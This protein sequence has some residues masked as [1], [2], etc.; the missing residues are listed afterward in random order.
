MI[1]MNNVMH[2]M[3][4]SYSAIKT[5]TTCPLKYQYQYIEKRSAE[6]GEAAVFGSLIH[7]ALHHYHNTVPIPSSEE[8]IHF[9]SKNWKSTIYDD[10]KVEQE[11]FREG[12]RVLREYCSVINPKDHHIIALEKPFQVVISDTDTS[13]S[14]GDEQIVL[15]GIIDRIEKLPDGRFEIIDYKTGRTLPSQENVDN[16]LQLSVYWMAVREQWPNRDI[17]GTVVSLYFVK[18]QEKIQS[19][20]TS[21][22]IEETK[23]SIRDIV[24]SIQQSKFSPTPSA[25]CDYCEYRKE[26]PMMKHK[27]RH[28]RKAQSEESASVLVKEYIQLKD[29]EKK[30]KKRLKELSAEL[31]HFCREHDLGRLF[32]PENDFSI[33]LSERVTYQYDE[34]QLQDIL[35]SIGRWDEV[36]KIDL[37]MLKRILPELPKD[38]QESIAALQSVKKKSESLSIK[39]K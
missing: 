12:V 11:R 25:L 31:L 32:G 24:S 33:A 8:L 28:E 13:G 10:E 36:L 3:R 22:Q 19:R 1:K 34:Q 16:D 7:S 5:Y 21:E 37:V 26:C 9:F 29:E 18:H 14:G 17:R 27:Y 4:T 2:N 15:T 6:K 38:M 30:L 23:R 39:R 20:R 35:K